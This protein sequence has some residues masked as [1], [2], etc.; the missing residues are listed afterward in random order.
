MEIGLHNAQ[1]SRLL[2]DKDGPSERIFVRLE[3]HSNNLISAIDWYRIYEKQM[4]L[5][6]LRNREIRR[7]ESKNVKV[8]VVTETN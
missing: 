5:A 6:L 1:L 3:I 2:N 8:K 7:I 4:E